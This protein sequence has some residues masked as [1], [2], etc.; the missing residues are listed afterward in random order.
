MASRGPRPQVARSAAL[1][2]RAAGAPRFR[3]GGACASRLAGRGLSLA[4]GGWMDVYW[5]DSLREFASCLWSQASKI[6]R[7]HSSLLG[8]VTM[9]HSVLVVQHC[10]YEGRRDGEVQNRAALDT[11]LCS[12]RRAY[13]SVSLVRYLRPAEP[14]RYPTVPVPVRTR[15]A[16]MRIHGTRWWGLSMRISP[17][18]LP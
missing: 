17:P 15:G 13:H 4:T 8:V 3:W 5:R 10:V 6:Q 9:Q 1:G 18:H 14:R 11:V 12:E 7:R 2:A 16:A